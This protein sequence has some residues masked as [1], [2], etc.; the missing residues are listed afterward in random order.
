MEDVAISKIGNRGGDLDVHV[1]DKHEEALNCEFNPM[2]REDEF[3]KNANDCEGRA[4]KTIRTEDKARWLRLAERWLQMAQQEAAKNAGAADDCGQGRN[5][6]HA[7]KSS[8]RP[9][10]SQ[11]RPPTE[12]LIP[13]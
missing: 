5:E 3:R 11:L 7:C 10:R 12:G 6:L 4:T 2:S 1:L 13:P 8:R 9:M